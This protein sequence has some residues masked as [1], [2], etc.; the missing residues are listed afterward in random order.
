MRVVLLPMRV[1]I[2]C[3]VVK[4][5]L[6]LMRFVRFSGNGIGTRCG[7]PHF[8]C[9][10]VTFAFP[11]LRNWNGQKVKSG[12]GYKTS[13]L[14]IFHFGP[15][16][17]DFFFIFSKKNFNRFLFGPLWSFCLALVDFRPRSQKFPLHSQNENFKI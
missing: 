1:N 3:C 7:V 10:L 13:G 16:M 15:G 5:K 8:H 2:A 4:K 9:T 14:L 17:F 12:L 11:S 6:E